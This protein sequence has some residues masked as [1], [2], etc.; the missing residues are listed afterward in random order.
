M[1]ADRQA[2]SDTPDDAAS[3]TLSAN[4]LVGV[5]GQD[6]LA[7]ARELLAQM[8]R[9]PGVALQQYFFLLGELA[10]IATGRSA[11]APAAQ[12][13]RFA[14]RAW[15]ESPAYRA[16]AQVYLAWGQALD[17]FVDQAGMEKREAQR[18]R[19]VVSLVVDA[20]AP[21]NSLGGNPAAL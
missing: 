15:K 21:T 8:A 16:L 10:R 7:A 20:L 14:D 2:L 5:R 19:F 17:R 6:I 3:H 18:A 1:H 11:L 12:D 9:R 4:P 13:K